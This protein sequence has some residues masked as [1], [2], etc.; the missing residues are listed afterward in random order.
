MFR[1]AFFLLAIPLLAAG[2]TQSDI[3]GKDGWPG[4][5]P[6]RDAMTSD[7]NGP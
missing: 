6:S 7:G 5:S 4:W 1:I 2:C 3:A